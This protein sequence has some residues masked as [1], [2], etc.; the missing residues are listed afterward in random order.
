MLFTQ[1]QVKF[2][3]NLVINKVNTRPDA[4]EDW[5]QNI[6]TRDLVDTGIDG[7]D[8]RIIGMIS[9]LIKKTSTTL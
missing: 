8:E 2:I 3:K 7:K 5:L 4:R 1:K 6:L 9:S